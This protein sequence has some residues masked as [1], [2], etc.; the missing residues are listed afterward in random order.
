MFL[1]IFSLA[2]LL[3]KMC[4]GQDSCL[5]HLSMVLNSSRH[6]RAEKDG[7]GWKRYEQVA[8][9]ST[10]FNQLS[11]DLPTCSLKLKR[12]PVACAMG[13]PGQTWADTASGFYC[14]VTVLRS[15]SRTTD[16]VSEQ[17][18]TDQNTASICKHIISCCPPMRECPSG[19][20]SLSRID[21]QLFEAGP[22]D[23]TDP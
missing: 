4:L 22:S 19:R 8:N 14:C 16:K 18:R 13:R 5:K 23:L 12:L 21:P 17:I 20:P 6:E 10:C 9:V 1:R 11:Q 7:S 3:Q 2:R 15:L